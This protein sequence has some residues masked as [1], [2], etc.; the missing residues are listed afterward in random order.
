MNPETSTVLISG[1]GQLGRRYLEGLERCQRP[2][3]IYVHDVQRNSLEQAAQHWNKV[4]RPGSRHEV[5]FHESSQSLPEM[6]D[7]AIV[8]T[9]ADVRPKVAGEIARRSPPRFWVLEKVLAQS[10]AALEELSSHVGTAKAWVNTARRMMPWHQEIRSR[11]IP[12][13]PMRIEVT[14][15]QWGLACNAVHFLDLLA[16]W[17]GERLE[18]ILT[19]DLDRWFESKRQNFL[20]V[21]GTLHARFSGGSQALLRS[22]E[23]AAVISIRIVEQEFSW[24]VNE[25]EGLAKRSDGLEIKGRVLYQSEMAATL[26]ESILGRGSCDL[27]ILEESAALHHAFLHG[28]HE[29]WRRAGHPSALCVPI[30]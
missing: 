22:E 2:L 29:H 17:T 5:S 3:R 6:L 1:A 19:N 23:N 7:V 30:T 16:W 4:T 25:A 18:E 10:E 9:T 13:P 20:E 8:A 21:S 28:M 12:G 26:V 24:L 15:G 11:L 14:G 27:P